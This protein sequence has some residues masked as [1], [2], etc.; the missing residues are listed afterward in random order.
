M[1]RS[2]PHGLG[3]CYPSQVI[4]PDQGELRECGPT[5]FQQ[6]PTV[7]L[8]HSL[9][10]PEPRPTIL[11]AAQKRGWSEITLVPFLNPNPIAYL[12]EHS[13]EAPVLIDRQETIALIDSSAQVS[14]VSSQLF[15]E[16][17]LED[18]SPGSVIGIRGDRGLSHPLPWVC[19]GQ[20]PDPRD[21]TL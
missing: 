7:N 18:P 13:N 19:G 10:D 20:P 4:K 1:S 9:P 2:G 6:Q 17:T 14:S 15:E 16:L 21:P 3:V 8:Q 5:H 12:V 11:K